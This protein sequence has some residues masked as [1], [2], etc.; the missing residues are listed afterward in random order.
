M[1]KNDGVLAQFTNTIGTLNKSVNGTAEQRNQ[2]GTII[3]ATPGLVATVNTHDVFLYGDPNQQNQPSVESRLRALETAAGRNTVHDKSFWL[4]LLIWTAAGG[5][6]GLIAGSIFLATGVPA[7][8]PSFGLFLGLALGC[9][10]S[11]FVLNM[12][13]ANRAQ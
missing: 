12:R 10:I 1:I 7:F 4:W 5:L 3:P 8:G 6:I 11:Y 13:R 9:V 2:D